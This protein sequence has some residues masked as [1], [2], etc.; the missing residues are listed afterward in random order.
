MRACFLI[1]RYS[2]IYFFI[3]LPMLQINDVNMGITMIK[4]RAHSNIALVKYWGKKNIALNTPAVGSISLCLEAL[5]TET[6]VLFDPLLEKDE[7]LLNGRPATEKERSRVSSFLDIIRREAG[8]KQAA[9]VESVNNFPTAAGLASSASAFAAL[10]LA[11]SRAAGLE[12]SGQEL[13]ILARMGSGSAARSLFGGFVEMHRGR[14]EDGRDAWAEPLYPAD[15]WPLQVIIAITSEVQ[16]KTGSTD[17]MELSRRT[18]PY[19]RAWVDSSEDDLAAMRAALAEKDFQKLA[20]VSEFSCLKMHALAMAS[21][22]GLIYWSAATLELLHWVR[23]LREQGTPVFFTI[24]AGPQLKI[25]C[26]PSYSSAIVDQL[27]GH[28]AVERTIVSA[29]GPDARVLGA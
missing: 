27:S 26:P 6:G 7:L 3:S 20:E 16:K 5:Y 29:L 13:S 24:D 10:A 21:N 8:S 28:P 2:F 22:P 25:I 12:L 17:G 23:T 11:A 19:Y 15:Y 4:A 14:R 1:S 18:S 9:R